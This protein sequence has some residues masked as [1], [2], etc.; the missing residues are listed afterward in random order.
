MNLDEHLGGPDHRLVH[1]NDPNHFRGA[2]PNVD[3]S[4]HTGTLATD[5]RP[6]RL[7]NRW[8]TPTGYGWPTRPENGGHLHGTPT[9]TTPHHS[10]IF[11][12]WHH[13]TSPGEWWPS[14]HRFMTSRT[15][16]REHSRSYP[17]KSRHS[18]GHRLVLAHHPRVMSIDQSNMGIHG[19]CNFPGFRPQFC[20]LATIRVFTPR[21]RIPAVRFDE[22]VA[23]F[24]DISYAP[25]VDSRISLGDALTPEPVPHRALAPVRHTHSLARPQL[26]YWSATSW[27]PEG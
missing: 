19:R 23:H 18:S 4:L 25:G 3:C 7:S 16:T 13:L 9:S 22:V 14:T 6:R 5:N 20:E 24:R 26:I 17:P 15:R 11:W 1:L 8:P 12:R 27:R 10:T 21:F 2:V